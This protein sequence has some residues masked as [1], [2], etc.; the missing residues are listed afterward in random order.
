MATTR[1]SFLTLAR[2][3]PVA[4]ADTCLAR[5]FVHCQ[6]CAD[7]CPEQAISFTPRIGGPPLPG[8]VGARCTACGECLPSCPVSA[9]AVAQAGAGV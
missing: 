1:R 2:P 4:I 9:I 7:A 5:Q 8:I 6:S 3:A